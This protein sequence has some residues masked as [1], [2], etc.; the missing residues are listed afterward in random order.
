MTHAITICIVNNNE[1]IKSRLRR[2]Y[3][4][5]HYVRF[6]KWNDVN[7]TLTNKQHPKNQSP[8]TINSEGYVSLQRDGKRVKEHRY[9]MEQHL[10]RKLLANENIHH[11]NGNRADN[12]IENLELWTIKQP[13]GKRPEDLVKF[14]HEILQQYEKDID[15]DTYNW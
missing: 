2:G 6:M 10:G 8:G 12:R 15:Y 4:Q 14:A 11:K 9:V 13:I 3:C 7:K 5:K 1:C